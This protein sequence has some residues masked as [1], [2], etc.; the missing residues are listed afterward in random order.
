MRVLYEFAMYSGGHI[1]RV[2]PS[3]SN[4][5]VEE[6]LAQFRTLLVHEMATGIRYL[7][8]AGNWIATKK[9][10]SASGN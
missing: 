4:E 7:L 6:I 8:D 2:S 3:E 5:R 9:Y 10:V 1:L